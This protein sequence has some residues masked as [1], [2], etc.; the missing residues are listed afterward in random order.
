[1][2]RAQLVEVLVAQRRHRGGEGTLRPVEPLERSA[3]GSRHL[4]TRERERPIFEGV[5]PVDVGPRAEMHE[6]PRDRRH[7]E[8]LGRRPHVFADP[9]ARAP[10]RVG[11]TVAPHRPTAGDGLPEVFVV[12][13]ILDIHE[14]GVEG[15]LELRPQDLGGSRRRLQRVHVSPVSAPQMLAQTR[16]RFAAWLA[17]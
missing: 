2:G 16:V 8:R 6:S 14:R 5:R 9:L 3:R 7:R 17:A 12:V 11:F 1:M 4:E 13:K 10:A 15:A